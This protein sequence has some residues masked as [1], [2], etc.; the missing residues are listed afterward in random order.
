VVSRAR[1]DWDGPGSGRHRESFSAS[2]CI[3][4]QHVCQALQAFIR[5]MSP[6]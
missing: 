6:D 3:R 5:A 4:I 1:V 2:G